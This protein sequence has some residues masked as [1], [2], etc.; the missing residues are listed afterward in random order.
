MQPLVLGDHIL[1]ALIAYLLPLAVIW[2]RPSTRI[3]IPQ[4]TGFKIRIY[5]TN[6]LILWLGALV[7]IVLWLIQGRNFVAMGLQLPAG[8]SFP[9]WMLLCAGFILLY[10]IDALLSWNSDEHHPAAGILPANWR[11]FGHFGTIVS[12]SAAVCEEVIFRGFLITYILTLLEGS[13]NA[14]AIAVV[15]SSFVFG[16]AH[17]YQG[18]TALIKITLLS[19]LFAVLFILTKSLLVVIALH[20]FIDFC[21]GFIA[22]MK[23]REDRRLARLIP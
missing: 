9:H 19:I 6:S 23:T 17:E 8:H 11:E 18:G 13:P 15:G 20:F 2:R 4:D 22:V 12:L 10:Y 21:S 3:E 1:F 14:T 7:I 16:I 5:W